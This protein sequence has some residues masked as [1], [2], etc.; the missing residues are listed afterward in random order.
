MNI[1]V[2]PNS[3][4]ECLDS[5]GVAQIISQELSKESKFNLLLK[6][7]SDGG[8]GFRSICSPIFVVNPVSDYKIIKYSDQLS[9]YLL[10][11]SENNQ[12]VFIESADLFGL[13]AIPE[14]ERNPLKLNSELLGRI[15]VFLT[16]ETQ[17]NRLKISNV[18]IGV[19]GT[20][21]I[22][23]GIGVCS[24]LGLTLFY[25]NDE[26]LTPV[27]INF[28]KTKKVSFEKK[29]IPF[30]INCVVDVETELIGN[31]GAIEIYGK[32]K[33]ANDEDFQMIK[34]GIKNLLKIIPKNLGLKIPEKLNGAGGG[35]AA[36][37][38]LFYNAELI[39]AKNFIQNNILGDVN[40]NEID[41]VITGEGSFDNQSFEGKGSGVILNLFKDR[42]T[43]IFLI[44]GSSSLSDN[45][46][47]PENT[48]IINLIDFFASKTE[49]INNIET[50][51][52]K[53]CQI[54]SN[55]LCL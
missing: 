49:S 29:Q 14:S 15:I 12:I 53:A 33:G 17:N 5:I 46:K 55:Q 2:A 31:P 28:S 11:Y 32:Q 6:P 23:F 54:V 42:S 41:V 24:Q 34:N 40:L 47:L 21:T 4:K 10:I 51:L 43:K 26:E 22:D 7:L 8:D 39:T 45:Y 3:F 27:P 37:L 50:G 13:K 48:Q 25:E 38:N 9:D 20:A 35:L 36:G 52:K 16:E 1:L 18:Y 30:K 19:G 44:N